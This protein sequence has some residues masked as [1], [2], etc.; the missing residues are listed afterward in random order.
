MSAPSSDLAVLGAKVE[1]SDHEAEER[2]RENMPPGLGRLAE[3]AEWLSAVQG[4]S[5]PRELGRVRLVVFG[6]VSEQVADLAASVDAAT[7]PVLDL[8]DDVEEAVAAGVALA[9]DEVDGG[10]DLLVVALPGTSPVPAAVVAVLTNTEP[11]KV[12]GRG[13]AAADPELWMA[14]AVRVR[15][16]RH[17]AFAARSDPDAMLRVLAA[18]ALAAAAGFVLQ[19]AARR[20][21]VLLDGLGATA[22]ALVAYEAQPRAVR[23]WLPADLEPDPA[24]QLALAKLGRQAVAELGTSLGDGTAGLLAVPVLRAAVQLAR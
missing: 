20:T 1:W 22:A 13:S 7:R 4:C 23:W 24:H 21:P 15:D 19:A 10:A 2:T 18:P 17:T 16:L 5:P 12:L 11:V 14:R 9:D 8:A 3:V 6:P